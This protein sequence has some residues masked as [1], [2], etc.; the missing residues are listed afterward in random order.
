MTFGLILLTY[1]EIEGI[2]ELWNQ[3]P[4]DEFDESFAVDGGSNDGTID[5]FNKKS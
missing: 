1:N 4:F 5:F 3:I 2:K